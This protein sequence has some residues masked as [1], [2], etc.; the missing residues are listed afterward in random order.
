MWNSVKGN[1]KL[2][3]RSKRNINIITLVSLYIR[4]CYP[5]V[6]I[7]Q[8]EDEVVDFDKK[9]SF[10]QLLNEL[11]SDLSITNT[12]IRSYLKNIRTFII[13]ADVY[14]HALMKLYEMKKIERSGW[15]EKGR[16]INKK[17]RVESD[18]DHTWACCML[19]NI[20]LTDR[21]EDCAFLSDEEKVKYADTYSLDKI[22]RLLLVHDLPEVYTGDIPAKKQDKEKKEYKRP[23]QCN[24]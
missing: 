19:A 24:L 12:E 21:I 1:R 17:T 18:A 10:V 14:S 16:E 20:F 7:Q 11:S 13:S 9:A 2:D 15:S 22:I 3:N 6:Q 5:E 8:R 4:I 23:M